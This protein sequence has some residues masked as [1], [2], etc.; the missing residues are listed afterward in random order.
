[1]TAN[2]KPS[3]TATTNTVI[4]VIKYRTNRLQYL[5]LQRSRLEKDFLNRKS[6]MSIIYFTFEE[7]LQWKIEPIKP[8]LLKSQWSCLAK[9]KNKSCLVLISL[10]NIL[11][12]K[13][14][15]PINS[16]RILKR[17]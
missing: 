2:G 4:P 9:K 8:I 5:L 14:K 15:I 6:H 12:R 16:K 3:G 13:T 7:I 11:K 1:M 17:D 10:K